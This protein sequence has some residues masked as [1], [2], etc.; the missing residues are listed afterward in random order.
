[1]KI[2]G[3]TLA[4]GAGTRLAPIS[5]EKRPKQF[6]PLIDDKPMIQITNERFEKF[7]DDQYTVTLKRYENYAKD[8]ESEVLFEPKRLETGFS[9][10][11][12]L[13]SINADLGDCYIIQTPSDHHIGNEKELERAIYRALEIAKEKQKIVMIGEQPNDVEP[14]YGHILKK[15]DGETVGKFYEKPVFE[16]AH[17]YTNMGALW[18]TAIYVYPLSAMMKEFVEFKWK[19]LQSLSF[20]LRASFDAVAMVYDRSRAFSFEKEVLSKSENLAVVE[21]AMNWSD[22]GTIDRLNEV[23]GEYGREKIQINTRVD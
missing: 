5:S 16:K 11:Y 15:Y 3:L 10:L 14:S 12:S 20:S 22:I 13:L 1:M 9:V 23:R 18:N 17:F 8:I 4:S 7:C 21:S 6:L 19:E 2:I